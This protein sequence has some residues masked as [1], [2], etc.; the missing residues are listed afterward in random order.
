[1][2]LDLCSVSRV[3][4]QTDLHLRFGLSQR[5]SHIK[6]DDLQPPTEPWDLNRA[7][8]VVLS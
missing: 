7:R 8:S 1:M 5:H 6:L 3:G 4:V 2:M